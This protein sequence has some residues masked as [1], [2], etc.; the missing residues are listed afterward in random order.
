MAE[1]LEL[2]ISLNIDELKNNGAQAKAILAGLGDEA[3]KLNAALIAAGKTNPL[4]QIN[5]DA[6]DLASSIA[7]VA[8]QF[9]G[10][11]GSGGGVVS[12]GINALRGLFTFDIP[13]AAQGFAQVIAEATRLFVS[14]V[15]YATHMLAAQEKTFLSYRLTLGGG[16]QGKGAFPGGRAGNALEDINRFS[17]QTAYSPQQIQKTIQQLFRAG[18]KSDT[19]GVGDL[20][21]GK[22]Q[23]RDAFAAATDV[24]AMS[25]HETKI[26]NTEQTL[27]F[28]KMTKIRGGFWRRQ[29]HSLAMN[30]GFT[31]EEFYADMAKKIG[32][33]P[34]EARKKAIKGE[35]PKIGAAAREVFYD[36]IE[37]RV[38]EAGIG[39]DA[40]GRYLGRAGE[41]EGKTVGAVLNKLISLPEQYFSKLA[42]SSS[43]AG[44]TSSL[45]ELYDTLKP[46]S[47]GGDMIIGAISDAFKEIVSAIKKVKA[48]DV[49]GF[50]KEALLFIKEFATS[51]YDLGKIFISVDKWL[52]ENAMLAGAL[53]L[54]L[55]VLSG[56]FG[57]MG[58]KDGKGGIIAG[59]ARGLAWVITKIGS[60]GSII[61]GLIPEIAGVTSALGL[62]SIGIAGT[63]GLMEAFYGAYL[64]FSDKAV[65]KGVGATLANTPL[66]SQG[67]VDKS[68][69]LNRGMSR[70]FD[71]LGVPDFS[72]E[73]SPSGVKNREGS[74]YPQ[75][76]PS[77]ATSMNSRNNVQVSA[78]ITVNITAAPGDD[79]HTGQQTAK[80]VSEHL[81]RTLE[82]SGQQAGMA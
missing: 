77:D 37:Q 81:Q 46:G 34:E 10:L 8:K 9:S 70:F 58:G 51:L 44:F 33:S 55:G 69:S 68:G 40:F 17:N 62:F 79:T 52:R 80:I 24:A 16:L 6:K 72:K 53:A 75:M 65:Q 32:G 15:Q 42:E 21:R 25:P 50:V 64:L 63:I 12:G 73:A 20:A 47:A 36:I 30:I 22:S 74:S 38:K 71:W 78:P 56:S 61:V 57:S 43:L 60:F 41:E 39:P 26:E 31:T 14:G 28:L 23:V 35:D 4:K 48:E 54:G 3:K 82:Q 76:L 59:L 11:F 13:T 5:K 67:E 66:N 7:S 49:V 19:G 27:E 45:K 1:N 18:F 29:L 2:K